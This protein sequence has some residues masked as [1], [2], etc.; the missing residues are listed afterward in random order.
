MGKVTPTCIALVLCEAVKRPSG[1]GEASVLR[2]FEF[3]EADNLPGVV[4]PFTVWTQLRDGNGTAA[5]TLIMEYLPPDNL[6]PV[7]LVRVRFNATFTSPHQ[8]VEH[9]SVMDN[10]RFEKAGRYR[11]RL[12][13]NDVPVMARDFTV[14]AAAK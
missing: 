13:A 14:V 12:L 3:F 11:L 6:E 8:V 4:Q 5:M 1:G 10:P 7:E 9:E 2:A